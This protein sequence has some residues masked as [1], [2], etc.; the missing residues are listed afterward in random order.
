MEFQYTCQGKVKFVLEEDFTRKDREES[1]YGCLQ[2]VEKFYKE[3][4]I[5]TSGK[6]ERRKKDVLD[7]YRIFNAKST[8]CYLISKF[9]VVKERQDHSPKNSGKD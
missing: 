2:K 3:N 8:P 9:Q 7:Y 4:L 6:Y 1:E 5:L